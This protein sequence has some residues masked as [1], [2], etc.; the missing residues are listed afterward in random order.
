[1]IINCCPGKLYMLYSHSKC[2]TTTSYAALFAVIPPTVTHTVSLRYK[3]TDRQT[4][5]YSKNGYFVDIDLFK[6]YTFSL[7]VNH[8]IIRTDHSTTTSVLNQLKAME[9]MVFTSNLIDSIH[10]QCYRGTAACAHD[11]V[12]GYIQPSIDQL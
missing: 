6:S 8:I 5:T 1:M 9:S 12:E 7:Y 3:S 11:E 2:K 10:C 4:L